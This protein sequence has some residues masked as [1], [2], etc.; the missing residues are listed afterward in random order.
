M[1]HVNLRIQSVVLLLYFYLSM[2]SLVQLTR[3]VNVGGGEGRGPTLAPKHV[4]SAV[5]ICY[6][7]LSLDYK[8]M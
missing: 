6:R 5:S 2:N 8:K 1:C 3:T 7:I 4:S